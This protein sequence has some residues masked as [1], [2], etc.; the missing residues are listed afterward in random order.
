MPSEVRLSAGHLPGALSRNQATFSRNP[1][2]PKNLQQVTG[3]TVEIVY[4]NQGCTE[5]TAA[6]ATEGHRIR[7]EVVEPL[8]PNAVAPGGVIQ[9]T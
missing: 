1:T 2:L 7:L 4:G 6:E 5:Q 9:P 3:G 8:M